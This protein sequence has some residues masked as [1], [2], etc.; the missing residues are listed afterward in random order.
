MK[1]VLRTG[2]LI[3]G[4]LLVF[5]SQ[6]QPFH[7]HL[8][9]RFYI[10]GETIQYQVYPSDAIRS[11]SMLIYTELYSNTGRMEIQQIHRLSGM[12]I[13]GSMPLPI[14][15]KEGNYRLVCYAMWD[16]SQSDSVIIRSFETVIAIYNE[17]FSKPGE[18]TGQIAQNSIDTSTTPV[19]HGMVKS[20]LLLPLQLNTAQQGINSGEYSVAVIHESIDLASP[21]DKGR[22]DQNPSVDTGRFLPRKHLMITGMVSDPFSLKP[23]TDRNL[24]LYIPSR[25]Y[26]KR[27][28][29]DHGRIKVMIPDIT[30]KYDIQVLSMNPNSRYP[31]NLDYKVSAIVP[32]P[33]SNV[34]SMPVRTPEILLALRQFSKKRLI[35]D[36]FEDRS[37][38]PQEI[39]NASKGFIPDKKYLLSDFQELKTLEDF[40][41]EV[42]LETHITTIINNK[43]SLR[44][45][46]KEKNQLYRWPAW[47]LLDGVFQADEDLMLNFDIAKIKS[48]ELFNKDLTIERQFDP[49]MKYNGIFSINTYLKE[50][51]NVLV[52]SCNG[53]TEPLSDKPMDEINVNKP[54]LRTSILWQSKLNCDPN[55]IVHLRFRSGDIKGKYAVVLNGTDQHGTYIHRQY[56]LVI[57]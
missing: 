35:D 25:Q 6:A 55:G 49:I 13:G 30:G 7:V 11:D 53:L 4:C 47:Y 12:S 40:I 44:L 24:S 32:A 10:V 19:Y 8:D 33:F 54:D 43:K 17:L 46:S 31:L 48:I 26:F 14:S 21:E 34:Q 9:Q 3:T 57:E 56:Q 38:Y 16:D 1:I 42:L 15:F 37:V 41:K 2:F 27:V 20:N 50:E 36:I 39:K 18:S 5:I 28:Q 45:R 23:I 29:S 51:P 22:M 52:Y